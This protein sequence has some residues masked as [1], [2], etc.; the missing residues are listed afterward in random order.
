MELHHIARADSVAGDAGAGCQRHRNR[1]RRRPDEPAYRPSRTI[2]VEDG[3][4]DPI[5]GFIRLATHSALVLI[6]TGMVLGI[7]AGVWMSRR[8]TAPL[9]SLANGAAEIGRGDLGVRVAPVS[10]THLDVYKRQPIFYQVAQFSSQL[11]QIL[12]LA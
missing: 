8:M 12:R 2:Q 10:Y 1:E 5:A 7:G 9:E 4:R 11:L 6:S 3:C